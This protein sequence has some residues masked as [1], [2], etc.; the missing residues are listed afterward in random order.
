MK[1]EVHKL[2]EPDLLKSY[3]VKGETDGRF[4]RTRNFQ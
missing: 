4:D 1:K 3:P 2:S